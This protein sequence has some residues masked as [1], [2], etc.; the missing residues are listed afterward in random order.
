MDVAKLETPVFVVGC[1][2]SGTTLLQRMLNQHSQIAIASE[3][4]FIWRFWRQRATYGD[5][6]QDAHYQ[7]LIEDIVA[8]PEFA[9]MQLNTTEFTAQAWTLPRCYR[10]LLS[11]LLVSF[12]QRQTAT[13]TGEKTPDHL[14]F[15]DVLQQFYPAA[16]FIHVVRDPRAVVNSWKTVPW[17]RGSVK[18]DA[19]IWR[20]NLRQ[21]RAYPATVHKATLIVAYEQ[22]VTE[23]TTVLQRICEF[24]QLNFE[25]D[26]LAYHSQSPTAISLQREPWKKNIVRPVDP[27]LVQRWQQQLTPAEVGTIEL[28][29]LSELWRWGYRPQSSPWRLAK[30]AVA[31]LQAKFQA[32]VQA[33]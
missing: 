11:L 8:M 6:Q 33:K 30:L 24:L 17:S 16:R 20:N 26:M 21:Y 27:A 15:L 12:A 31:T 29:T 23:P 9:E 1:P 10:N 22:L 3:T 13:V 25:A 28:F 18:E 14:R 19:K 4:H 7:R 5:L 2:R 32:S